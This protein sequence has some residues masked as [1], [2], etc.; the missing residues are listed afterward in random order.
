[1]LQEKLNEKDQ[2]IQRL[3]DELQQKKSIENGSSTNTA[4]NARD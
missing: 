2:E 1:M 4:S 3:K